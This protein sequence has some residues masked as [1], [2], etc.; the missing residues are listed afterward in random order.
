MV[1]MVQYRY[2]WYIGIFIP[3]YWQQFWILRSLGYWNLQVHINTDFF[4]VNKKKSHSQYWRIEKVGIPYFCTTNLILS[5]VA[6]GLWSWWKKG[7]IPT[8]GFENN[9]YNPRIKIIIQF[10]IE[11][12]CYFFSWFVC[13][14]SQTL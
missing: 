12:N 3:W 10:E 11:L 4:Y 8:S 2:F 9:A 1:T 14:I 5:I 7:L 13:I 6:A